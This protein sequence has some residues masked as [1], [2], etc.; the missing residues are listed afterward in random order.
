MIWFG[1]LVYVATADVDALNCWVWSS[2]RKTVCMRNAVWVL[3][4]VC[5]Y[6][7][8]YSQGVSPRFRMS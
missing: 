6:L 1:N 4:C 3:V 2:G 8:V 7:S 5:V